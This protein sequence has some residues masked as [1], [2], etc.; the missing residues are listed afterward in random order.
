MKA[1]I[2][3]AA[4]SVAASLTA[5]LRLPDQVNL[6]RRPR[7]NEQAKSSNSQESGYMRIMGDL[8]WDK[9]TSLDEW[10]V[11][12]PECAS[13]VPDEY[14][15]Y[16][17]ERI[18]KNKERY[19]S[20]TEYQES[21][22][23]AKDRQLEI[24]YIEKPVDYMGDETDLI[25]RSAT[26]KCQFELG[27]ITFRI[28]KVYTIENPNTPSNSMTKIVSIVI[29]NQSQRRAFL[30]LLKDKYQPIT[31]ELNSQP[32]IKYCSKFTCFNEELLGRINIK[33]TDY[34]I[35]LLDA[36]QVDPAKF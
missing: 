18:K 36:V 23:A 11:R 22:A 19:S 25:Y 2:Y 29:P 15:K 5:C 35:S 7:S 17:T 20:D 32:V 14:I 31:Y 16:E 8:R 13:R 30:A 26:P 21:L 24:G 34:T 9:L 33:P 28:D 10:A 4:L 1:I 3:V 12:F 6:D 27:G